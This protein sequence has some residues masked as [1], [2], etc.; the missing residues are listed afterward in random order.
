VVSH[1]KPA[2]SAVDPRALIA[3]QLSAANRL[4]VNLVIPSQGQRWT[5]R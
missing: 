4:G 3:R 1:I 5:F 2:A